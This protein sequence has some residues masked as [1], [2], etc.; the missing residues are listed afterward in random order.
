MLIMRS[1]KRHMTEGIELP[2]KDQNARRKGNLLILGNTG[3]GHHETSGDERE[4]KKEY[5]RRTRRLLET[6]L[7]SRNRIKEINNWSFT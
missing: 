5:L 1:G 4:N 6:K 3:N 2:R 7:Y